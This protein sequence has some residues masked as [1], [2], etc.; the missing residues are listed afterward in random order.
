MSEALAGADAV[1]HSAGVAQTMSGVPE[2][3]YRLLNT[4]ATIK[5]ARAAERAGVRRFVFLSSIRAQSG[6][7][8]DGVLHEA[9]GASADRRLWQVQARC[10]AGIGRDQSRLGGAQARARLWPRRAGQH[11]AARRACPLALSAAA[12]EPQGEALAALARQS[13][14]GRRQGPRCAFRAQAP[15]HRRRSGSLDHRRDDHG[16]APRSWPPRWSLSGAEPGAEGRAAGPRPCRD[17]PAVRW[18]A[19]C[20]QLCACRGSIGSRP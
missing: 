5:L 9:L 6:S 14:R 17:L 2:D 11:G 13:G 7:T 20:R 8:A 4:E 10:R 15:L 16:H 18:I 12:R 3:D 1:I 19:R